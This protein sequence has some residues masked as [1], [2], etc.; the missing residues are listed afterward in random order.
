MIKFLVVTNEPPAKKKKKRDVVE[1]SREEC[2]RMLK[3]KKFSADEYNGRASFWRIYRMVRNA[4]K[5]DTTWAQCRCGRID[6]YIPEKG[7]K[8]M[9]NHYSQCNVLEKNQS[10]DKFVTKEKHITKEEKAAL[11][12]AT[13]DFCVRDIRPF[14][15][16]EGRG[17]LNLLASV[18]LLSAKY[19]VLDESQ[20]Q[21]FLPCRS[22]VSGD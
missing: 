10:L 9:S 4:E 2:V 3:E 5:K 16:I 12:Q 21:T 17:L 14:H 11:S 15:A 6:E 18:S 7:T 1:V 19:G 8:H 22:T 13:A 20:L